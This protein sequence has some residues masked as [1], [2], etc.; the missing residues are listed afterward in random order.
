[1]T[2]CPP[3][4]DLDRLLRD[5]LPGDAL[6][7][8]A[9]HI[10][11]C[12][13]CQEELDRLAR[14]EVEPEVRL[15]RTVGD[16]AAT[17]AGDRDFDAF[18]SRIGHELSLSGDGGPP[19]LLGPG[20]AA[21]LPAID[22]Y[23]ILGELGR[24]GMG[25]VYKALH[26]RLNRLV[27]LKMILAGPQLAATARERFGRE[28]QAVARLRHP[29]IV[30]VYDFGEQDGR[31]YFSMELVAG[32]SLAGRLDGGPKPSRWSA[33]LVEVLARAVDY[34]H[35]NGVL[36][37]DLKPGNILVEAWNGD[38]AVGGDPADSPLGPDEPPPVKITDFGLSKEITESSDS[39]TQT[40]TVLGTPSYMSPEQARGRGASVGA[41]S[42][43]YALGVILYELLTGRPP[44]HSASPLDTL[45]QVAHEVPVSVLRLQPRVPHDLVTICMKCLEKEPR[46]RYA[47]AWDLAEDL[48]RFL[49][50]E[51][52]RAR[53][54]GIAGR[55]RRWGRR[56]P[57]L[58][59]MIG[60][61]CLVT[62][63]GFA[64]VLAAWR[65]A[66]HDR[67]KAEALA[68][69][70]SA[71]QS[72]AR[73][74]HRSAER[75]NAGLIID[76]ALGL[77]EA[78][79]VAAGLV[80][81]SQ[82]LERA[83]AVGAEELTPAIRA[84]LAAWASRL[85]VPRTSP[86]QGAST[87]SVAFSPDGRYLLTGAWDSK[88]GNAGPGQA[89]LWVPE[90]WKPVG[91]PTL[92]PGPVVA[93]AF[94]PD[95]RRVLTGSLDGT[96][97]LRDAATDRAVIEAKSLEYRLKV[98]AFSPVGSW[99]LTGGQTSAGVGVVDRW[100]AETG[101]S[102]GPALMQPGPVEAA[103][104]SPDGRLILIGCG[105]VDG[106]GEVVGGVAQL[107]DAETGQPAGRG[108]MHSDTV[109]SVAFSPDGKTVLTGC[110][111]TMARL[112][113]RETGQH[114]GV[115]QPHGFPVLALAFSPDGKTVVSGAGRTKPLGSDEG[116][117]RIWDVATGKLL[118]GRLSLDT[119]IHSVA[120]RPDGRSLATGSRDGRI[121]IWDVGHLRPIREW[122][123]PVPVMA[124]A[125]SPDGKLMITA[126][127][128]YEEK[129]PG[130][131]DAGRRP[132]PGRSAGGASTDR[133]L[134][135]LDDVDA[136]PMIAVME[137]SA[138]VESVAFSPDGRTLAT[139]S[140]DGLLRLWD[141]GGRPLGPP[142]KQGG[143]VHCLVFHPDGHAVATCGDNGPARIWDVPSGRPRG[144]LLGHHL[145]DRAVAF[146]PDGRTLAT[147]SRDGAVRLWDF[148]TLRTI[149]SP[150]SHGS[151]V[152]TV[153]FS[154]DG[155]TL[156]TGCAGKARLWDVATGRL[157]V[158][159]LA[160]N[161]VVW[162][163]G[164]GGHGSRFLTVAGSEYRD[165]GFV[166]LWDAKTFHPFGPP[167]PQR[168]SVTAVAFHPAAQLVATGGW[169]GDV[170]IWDVASGRPVGPS[171]PQR[172]SVLAL[173]FD[174]TGRTLAAAG[175]DG[176]CRIWAVPDPV[177]GTA[178]EVRKLVESVTGLELDDEG[179]IRSRTS[180][181]R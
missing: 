124:M 13:R 85:L 171:L 160:H 88:W 14:A 113:D 168:I 65:V 76:R 3:R 27:A 10:E 165:W 164:Y 38:V 78:G 52:I 166:R 24:G 62:V 73:G 146:S 129:L 91:P 42:D 39:H 5:E 37:R 120:F 64:G 96:I 142:R 74:A 109:K 19:G 102:L 131:S 177:E 117:V 115:P 147:A 167:L 173:A 121:R 133:G 101:R 81:L 69:S 79:E 72:E 145:P 141:A 93:V 45:L 143:H 30:Q 8:I 43:V 11:R 107:W 58:A 35:R 111:D 110:D 162:T 40:G 104:I 1:M 7:A 170:R 90:G 174:P 44:F 112:W 181:G 157:I 114:V 47:T 6:P 178:G 103:A 68:A 116:E 4:E 108:L 31:P 70:E 155:R 123:R 53:P 21:D 159:P 34:A 89:Q 106:D 41:T 139:G 9:E 176:T 48:R 152:M 23:A 16:D 77:C 92:H 63:A 154:P 84:N 137:H 54:V 138:P 128:R 140:R 18:L 161:G 95:G 61:L 71:A 50:H 55:L 135:W 149:G 175:E 2:D 82:G 32:G 105:P 99:F 80:W 25:V 134:A 33:R 66:V 119:L 98:L 15:L 83:E 158:P 153:V 22:G 150:M 118:V 56:N 163:V 59:G 49:D 122:S 87:M 172:G 36:H 28:A 86:A 26:L 156:L 144:L 20:S 17:F 29:N 100:D 46:Q 57:S 75:A 97:R 94:S 180:S 60:V 169:E 127:G 179:A 132:A 12:A 148:A 67:L 125:Y 136:G 130:N 151:E 51:P 126:G